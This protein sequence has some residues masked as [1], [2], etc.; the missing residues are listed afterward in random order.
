M[1]FRSFTF[2]EEI[3]KGSGIIAVRLGSANGAMLDSDISTTGSTLTI[4]PVSDLLPGTDYFITFDNGSVLDLAGNR[5]TGS[6]TYDFSTIA[7]GADP[8]AASNNSSGSSTETVLEGIAA[9]G[10]I[11]WLA[12]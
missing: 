3:V 1:L 6:S 9:F 11:A 7:A 12:L 10:I 8:Y 5:Y 4:N 2:S